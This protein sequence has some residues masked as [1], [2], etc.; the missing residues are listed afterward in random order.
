MDIDNEHRAAPVSTLCELNE[1]APACTRFKVS[2]KQGRAPERIQWD[3]ECSGLGIRLRQATGDGTWVV[4]W[5]DRGR[6]RNRSL[7]AVHHLS[8]DEARTLARELIG[9][10][11]PVGLALPPLSEGFVRTFLADCAGRWKP[12]TRA[13]VA[14]TC[15]LH[16]VP[17]LGG[18]RINE[19]ARSDVLAWF[20][21]RNTCQSWALSVLSS[22]M[23][24][25]EALRYREPN[26]NPCIGLRRKKTGFKL[27]IPTPTPIG[28]W[29]PR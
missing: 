26:S 3:K 21:A 14:R 7:G 20:D 19:I 28:A 29:A 12:S 25:A 17:E 13:V 18:R 4:Q 1:T 22:L 8:R 15:R 5:R 24:H 11:V 6:S 27:A 10:Q 23:I 2:V 16:V 9:H